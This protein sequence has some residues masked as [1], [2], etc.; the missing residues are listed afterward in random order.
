[1]GVG[2]RAE[3]TGEGARIGIGRGPGKG[4]GIADDVAV[5]DV[6]DSPNGLRQRREQRHNVEQ[7]QNRDPV[8]PGQEIEDRNA[9]EDRAV[10]GHAAFPQS[11]DAQRMGQVGGRVILHHEV[12]AATDQPGDGHSPE[13][14]V[15]SVARGAATF[16]DR[17]RHPQRQAEAHGV[18]EP[19]PAHRERPNMQQDRVDVDRDVRENGGHGIS[20][21]WQ[22]HYRYYNVHYN[23]E[24]LACDPRNVG[25]T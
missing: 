8:A 14:G 12:Q 2:R 3:R 11:Q 20:R 22:G 17:Q 18:H 9:Q 16:R 5:D 1:M 10:E 4:A 7:R 19:V 6:A 13:D 24:S 15:E 23:T 21:R 25:G